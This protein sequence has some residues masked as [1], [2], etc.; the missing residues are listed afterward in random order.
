MESDPDP[1]TAWVRR[2]A[3]EPREPAPPVQRPLRLRRKLAGAVRDGVAEAA[4]ILYPSTP[5]AGEHLSALLL[6]SDSETWPLVDGTDPIDLVT[7]AREWLAVADP[8]ARPGVDAPVLV[9]RDA[10]AE[11]APAAPRTDYTDRIDHPLLVPLCAAIIKAVRKQ[12]VLRGDDALLELWLD[13]EEASGIDATRLPTVP[14]FPDEEDDA[15]P[16]D[17]ALGELQDVYSKRRPPS[18]APLVLALAGVGIV[19][20]FSKLTGDGGPG[21]ISAAVL[22]AAAGFFIG[23]AVT[24]DREK[25]RSSDVDL[26]EVYEHGVVVNTATGE[27][28]TVKSVRLW[29][30]GGSPIDRRTRGLKLVWS[31]GEHSEPVF[32]DLDSFTSHRRLKQA[33]VQGD[34]VRVESPLPPSS[35]SPAADG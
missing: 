4:A 21:W 31:P 12:A 9:D 23:R 34:H 17:P 16:A 33:L 20:D 8:D 35:S 13:F 29:A 5:Q 6:E 10:D 27:E 24:G 22:L 7:A 11:G 28:V 3:A 2:S 14:F 26:L 32:T 19:S 15:P 18:L 1:I 25:P 30:P